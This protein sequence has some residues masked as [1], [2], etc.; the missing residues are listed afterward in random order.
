[1][2]LWAVTCRDK[3]VRLFVDKE[4]A[5]DRAW[6][7]DGDSEFDLP[8]EELTLHGVSDEGPLPAD[9]W[10][11][12][13]WLA[14]RPLPHNCEKIGGAYL[15][16]REAQE[17]AKDTKLKIVHATADLAQELAETDRNN[18]PG[19]LASQGIYKNAED[20]DAAPKPKAAKKKRAPDDGAAE[21]K[22]AKK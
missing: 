3:S 14:F 17:A 11:C 18:P 13:Q 1:M 15:T 22:A 7:E 6:Q 8:M 16:F 21:K 5:N 9:V 2:Q 20:P 4:K 10:M 19:E 12:G